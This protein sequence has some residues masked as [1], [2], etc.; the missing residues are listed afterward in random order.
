MISYGNVFISGIQVLGDIGKSF[1]VKGKRH[2]LFLFYSLFLLMLPV[3]IFVSFMSVP[4]QLIELTSEARQKR[5]EQKFD[6]EGRSMY[7]LW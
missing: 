5:M 1:S 2:L 3:L 6:E 4:F 7:P